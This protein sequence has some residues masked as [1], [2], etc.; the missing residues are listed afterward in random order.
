MKWLVFMLLCAVG[1][2]LALAVP[3]KRHQPSAV[4]HQKPESQ[5][6]KTERLSARC[7]A[8]GETP[9]ERV[10]PRPEIAPG[11]PP[12]LTFRYYEGAAHHQFSHSDLMLDDAGH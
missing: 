3:P 4:R 12:L 5:K 6:L 2:S 8:I 9:D 10:S 7:V 1:P 11:A